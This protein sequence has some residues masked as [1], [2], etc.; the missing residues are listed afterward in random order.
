[1][2]F[3]NLNDLKEFKLNLSDEVVTRK[4]S[5]GSIILMKM[6]DG[7][8]FYKMEGVSSEV[9][10]RLE[11]GKSLF[12]ISTEILAEYEVDEKTLMNDLSKL[13]GDLSKVGLI[14]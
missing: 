10:K 13:I 5:D 8:I 1:M 11:A 4:N 2:E 14:N 9:Y 7:D 12:D 6:D 3:S